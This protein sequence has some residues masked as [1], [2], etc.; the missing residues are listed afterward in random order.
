MP[1]I[2]VDFLIKEAFHAPIFFLLSTSLFAMFKSM[3]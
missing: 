2:A 1:N 3:I